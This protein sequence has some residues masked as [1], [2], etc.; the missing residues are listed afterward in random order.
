MSRLTN[1]FVIF[2]IGFVCV[3]MTKPQIFFYGDQVRPLIF[4]G[5]RINSL[6]TLHIF[7]IIWAIISHILASR[8]N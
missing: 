7:V 1:T 4:N 6:I 3:W 5:Q 8:L 2:T